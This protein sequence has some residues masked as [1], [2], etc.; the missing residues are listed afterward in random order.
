MDSDGSEFRWKVYSDKVFTIEFR[1]GG[2]VGKDLVCIEVGV[3]T[4]VVCLERIL[5][6]SS[7]SWI[8]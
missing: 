8:L 2:E 7:S 5:T 1:A 4:G 6:C 3:P